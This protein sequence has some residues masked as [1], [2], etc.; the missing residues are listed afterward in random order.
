MTMG[1]TLEVA[2][3]I[4]ADWEIDLDDVSGADVAGFTDA[5][6]LSADVWP[7]GGAPSAFQPSVSWIDSGTGR[8]K[9]TV[10]ASQTMALGVGVYAMQVWVTANGVRRMGFDGALSISRG[11]TGTE[12]ATGGR[13]YTT[14]D[15]MKVYASFLQLL[16]DPENDQAGYQLQIE[17]ASRWLEGL[18]M[19]HF[20]PN[21]S[22]TTP[23]DYSLDHMFLGIGY[24]RSLLP[25]SD[26]I[27]W[28]A[29][30]GLMTACNGV[31]L[32]VSEVV[33]KYAIGLVCQSK[34]GISGGGQWASLAAG[35]LNAAEEKAKT[36]TLAID[37]DADGVPNQW[38]DLG[39]TDTIYG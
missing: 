35:Y 20:R 29:A 7:G 31:D 36:L 9:L 30:G 3:N 11:R 25:P 10:G 13:T 4:D 22:S 1:Q 33:A 24:R 6:S 12:V 32:G 37:T 28:I 21:Q 2:Q 16:H 23:L 34:I 39:S 19:R 5:D 26:L 18:A 15:R 27:G 38:I 8:I 14:F 17:E